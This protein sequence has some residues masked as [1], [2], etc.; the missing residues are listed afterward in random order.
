ME[1]LAPSQDRIV[2]MISNAPPSVVEAILNMGGLTTQPSRRKPKRKGGLS[3]VA[4]PIPISSPK[5][6]PSQF[7]DQ[8]KPPSERSPATIEREVSS[9]KKAVL[10]A[11][12][13]LKRSVDSISNTSYPSM[14]QNYRI[15][16]AGRAVA[17]AA[18]A[19]IGLGLAMGQKPPARVL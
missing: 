17:Q 16:S 15:E 14:D 11:M 8:F 18:S 5:P 3:M 6:I 7:L 12:E 13:S 2:E 10:S 9:R 19:F 1:S 4:A